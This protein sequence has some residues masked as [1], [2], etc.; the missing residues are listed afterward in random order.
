MKV[1]RKRL[2]IGLKEALEKD[3]EKKWKEGH[4]EGGWDVPNHPLIDY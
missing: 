1:K 2:K 4:L 3:K